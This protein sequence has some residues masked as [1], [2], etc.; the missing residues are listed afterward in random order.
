MVMNIIVIHTQFLPQINANFI[1]G[2][3]FITPSKIN[4][5]YVFVLKL[6]VIANLFSCENS[7]QNWGNIIDNG[8]DGNC[9]LLK[10]WQVFQFS[11]FYSLNE[12]ALEKIKM[13]T[14]T[15]ALQT[16]I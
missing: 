4:Y 1:Y 12:N 2:R 6:C 8:D 14:K 15:W 10:N 3:M 9:H 13:K 16:C 7:I 11:I 5:F